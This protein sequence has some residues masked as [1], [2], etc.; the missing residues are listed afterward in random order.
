MQLKVNTEEVFQTSN[1]LKNQ[2]EEYAAAIRKIQTLVH[3]TSNIWKGDDNLALVGKM[4]TFQPQLL[5]IKT[6]M[7]QYA[8]YLNTCAIQY[9]QIQQERMMAAKRLA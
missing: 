1:F 2:S 3:E 8:A 6:I 9:N 7:E 5:K 4:D